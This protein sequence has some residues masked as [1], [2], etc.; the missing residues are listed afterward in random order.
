MNYY[1]RRDIR[2][3]QSAKRWEPVKNMLIGRTLKNIRK[4]FSHSICSRTLD[5][6]GLYQDSLTF[7]YTPPSPTTV[8]FRYYEA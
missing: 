3:E 6:M 7:K 8:K 2:I 4:N 1:E 5:K